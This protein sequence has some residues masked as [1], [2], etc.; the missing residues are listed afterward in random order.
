M[1]SHGDPGSDDEQGSLL[2]LSESN[3]CDADF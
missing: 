2:I 1:S 3:D